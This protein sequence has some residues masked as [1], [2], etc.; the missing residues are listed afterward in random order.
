MRSK[1][2]VNRGRNWKARVNHVAVDGKCFRNF[3][4]GLKQSWTYLM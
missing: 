4:N 3:V 2:T 1:I